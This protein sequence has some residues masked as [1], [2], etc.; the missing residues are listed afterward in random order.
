ME[1]ITI[2]ELFSVTYLLDYLCIKHTK[3]LDISEKK[4]KRHLRLYHPHLIKG[5][6]ET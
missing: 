2:M 4:S 5:T 3:D 6:S 1:N